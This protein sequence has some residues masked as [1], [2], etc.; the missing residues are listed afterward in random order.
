MKVPAIFVL[1]VALSGCDAYRQADHSIL[2][3]PATGRAFHVQPGAGAISYVKAYPKYD[4]FCLK[5]KP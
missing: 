2:C 4:S 5:A 3:D 1:S